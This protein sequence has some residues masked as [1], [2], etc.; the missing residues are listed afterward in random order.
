MP[1]R[2]IPTQDAVR[3]C[4]FRNVTQFRRHCPVKPRVRNA[5]PQLYLVDDLEAWLNPAQGDRDPE[6]EDLDREL[7]LA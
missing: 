7:G 2:L 4:G 6:M 5:R 1:A 3:Y